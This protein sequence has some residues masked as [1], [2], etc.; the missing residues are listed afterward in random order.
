MSYP[1]VANAIQLGRA[2]ELMAMAAF[3][4]AGLKVVMVNQQGF[5]LM[6][7][8]EDGHGY[9]VEVKS[10]SHSTGQEVVSYKFMTSSG[11]KSKKLLNIEDADIVC[12]VALDMKRMVVRCAST[13]PQKRTT[14]KMDE[15]NEPETLQIQRAIK[16]VRSR[17]DGK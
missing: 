9:R 2:G 3:E 11:S 12:C 15:F 14:I 16:T 13:F 10:C 6:A 5:D 8:D 1:T 4:M 17:K 7:F